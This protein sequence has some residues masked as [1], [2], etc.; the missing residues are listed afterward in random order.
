MTA[1]RPQRDDP[2]SFCGMLGSHPAMLD[3]FAGI[4][5]AAL[6]DA[7]VVVYGPTGSGKELVARALHALSAMNDG[8]LCVVNVS[9]LPDTLVESELFGSSR[10]AFTGA[11]SD[12]RGLIESAAGGTLFL[13]EAGELPTHVQVKLLRAL[14]YGEV[15]RIGAAAA[16]AT[17][18]RLAVAVQTDPVAL[19]DAGRWRDDFYYRVTGVV[20]RVPSLAERRTDIP[21]LASAFARAQGLP[22][23]DPDAVVLLERHAWRGNVRELQR[24]LMRA[25]YH[26]TGGSLSAAAVRA[27]LGDAPTAE[28]S[29]GSSLDGIKARHVRET[30]A[31]YAGDTRRAAAALG[32]SRSHV[33]RLLRC[34]TSV[35]EPAPTLA[36]ANG[37]L[38]GVG[39][40][41]RANASASPPSQ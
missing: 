2:T 3:L 7:P 19:R 27:A 28:P 37:G 12:R 11:V 31:A 4:K 39:G 34:A 29:R 24:S 1:P 13:D 35:Q 36:E 5:R 17:R 9:A 21:M 8:P 33:Y 20:L 14:E 38:N 22:A 30:V 40:G 26:A 18:F 10:G 16:V 25:A 23:L 6:L 41:E 32:I 15:R